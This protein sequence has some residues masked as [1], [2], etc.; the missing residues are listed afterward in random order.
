ML[1]KKKSITIL[2]LLSKSSRAFLITQKG[3]PGFLIDV[4]FEQRLKLLKEF[5]ILANLE[6]KDR[7][8]KDMI[9]C[10]KR[11]VFESRIEEANE[12]QQLLKKSKVSE[13]AL[14]HSLDKLKE[15]EDQLPTLKEQAPLVYVRAL[16]LLGRG[17][18]ASDYCN[19]VCYNDDNL[20]SVYVQE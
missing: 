11:L 9:A 1:N 19:N 2:F 16:K 13:I 3:L 7:I 5:P 6:A 10:F 8:A 18:E 17:K 14:L 20:F 15:I 12:L 4:E